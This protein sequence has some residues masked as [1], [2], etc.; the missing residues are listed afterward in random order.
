[1][2]NR[3]N[4]GDEEAKKIQD[5]M[6]YQVSKEI[7]A[8][9]TV[10]CGK[11]DAIFMSGGLVYNPQVIS[12]IKMRAGFIAPIHLYPGE[13]EMEALSQGAIRVLSGS[14]PALDY[15]Y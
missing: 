15:P 11:V 3:V 6:C 7:G 2:E 10:L 14:E 5:A 12:E 4:A 8:C 9:A 1:V 13:K